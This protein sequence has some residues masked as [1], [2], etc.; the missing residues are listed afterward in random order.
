MFPEIE[1]IALYVDH[2]K[3][4]S[5]ALKYHLGISKMLVFL[6]SVAKLLVKMVNSAVGFF[7]PPQ[8]T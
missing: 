8:V 3:K 7:F 4:Q 5:V 6:G 2:G 1:T